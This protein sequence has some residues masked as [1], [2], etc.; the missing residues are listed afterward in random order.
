VFAGVITAMVMS[1]FFSS[2]RADSREDRIRCLRAG[3]IPSDERISSC[4]AALAAGIDGWVDSR[5]AYYLRGSAYVAKGEF[6]AGVADF[7]EIIRLF[8]SDAQAY[9]ARA[10]A[11]HR[12]GDF[13]LA[14]ADYTRVIEIDP[15]DSFAY[16]YYAYVYRGDAYAEKGDLD[17]SI[18]DAS[19]AIEIN[20]KIKYAYCIRGHAY[21]RKGDVEPAIAD[22]NQAIQL[23]PE[24]GAAYDGRAVAYKVKGNFDLAVA[25]YDQLIRLDPKSPGAYRARGIAKFRAG[26]FSQALE[27]L[28]SSSALD[29]KD[30]YT[31]LWLDLAAKR[32]G[33]ASRL[34]ELA[35]QVDKSKWP[36]P[37]I[38]FLLGEITLPAMFEAAKDGNA[39]KERGQLCGAKF[40]SGELALQRGAK[41]EAARMFRSVTSDCP[42]TFFEYAPANAELNA[43]EAKP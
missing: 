8:P 43:L 28:N 4:T 41:D 29:P 18:A 24:Y 14:I 6:E 36:A 35:A 7:S 38:R 27:D 5:R 42:K 22:F 20:P 33:Q 26:S 9:Q 40:F 21:V 23:D 16:A 10:L 3:K 2:A 39:T 37:I 17:H 25:D 1:L 12:H 15:K 30:S 19:K 31:A 11:H 34:P 32:S 13:D